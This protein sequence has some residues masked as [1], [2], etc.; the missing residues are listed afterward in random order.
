[1]LK[2]ER[3]KSFWWEYGKQ[4][5]MVTPKGMWQGVQV[6]VTNRNDAAAYI[7]KFSWVALDDRGREYQVDQAYIQYCSVHGL[8]KPTVL[9]ELGVPTKIGLLFDTNPEAKTI[10]GLASYLGVPTARTAKATFFMADG[11]FLFVVTRGDMEVSETKLARLVGARSLQ[12]ATIE[13]IQ[14]VGAVP[15]Y[16]SPVGLKGVRVVVDDLVPRSRNL[17]AGA[18]REGY[19]LLNVNYGR[20]F[21]ADLV[22]DIVAARAGD[23]C[24]H[25]GRGLQVI[26]GTAVGSATQWGSQFGELMK[27]FYLDGSGK[28]QPIAV[29]SY[30]VN[31]GR[32][33]AC[34]VEQHHDDR[35]VLWPA[36]VAPYQLYLMAIGADR[37]PEVASTTERLFRELSNAGVET[38]YDDRN[39]S[40]GVKFGDADLIGLPLRLAVG[41]RGLAQ[42]AVELKRR[43]DGTQS[44]VKLEDA[45]AEVRCQ[46]EQLLRC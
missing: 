24:P 37:S 40:P 19:H 3:M 5:R 2:T 26:Q 15:G 42:G 21:V 23:P 28:S 6:S 22:G 8:E 17:V 25:C 13:D 35:G 9:F 11:R 41:Q 36:T 20:D 7:N 12:T 29:G 4:L 1:M 43:V 33:M 38:L 10:A 14:A 39:E 46:L 27:A 31:I 45:V 44:M 30:G 32:L 34:V 18:N 16:A